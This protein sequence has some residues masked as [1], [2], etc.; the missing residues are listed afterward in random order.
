MSLKSISNS[1]AAQASSVDG[2]V[3]S[4]LQW[5]SCLQEQWLIVFD[6]ADD[7]LPETVAN[8]IPPGN[9]G[10]ILMTSRNQSM[11]TVIAFEKYIEITEM[12]E[13][14]AIDLLLKTSCVDQAEQ[15]ISA[16]QKIVAEL[17]YIPLA[18]NHAGAYIEAGKSD[19]SHYLRRFL[20]H[21]QALMSDPTFTGR[22]NYDRT[23]YG[24]W[25]LSFRE[26]E[27]RA[28][29]QST[30]AQATQA[31]ILIFQICA[32]YHHSNIAK[33]IFRSAAEESRNCIQTVDRKLHQAIHQLLSLDNDGHWDDY[34]FEEGISV[35]FSFSL[36]KRG[37]SSDLFAIHPLVHCWSREQMTKAEKKRMCQLGSTILSCAVSWGETSWDYALRRLILPHIMTN[38]LHMS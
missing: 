31:A 10:N 36:M 1:S 22:S 37:E 38:E 2:S 8:F 18:I 33:D 23:V 28:G 30:A 25:D 21:R 24:T 29:G 20:Q 13:S 12:K 9:Q 5:I 6:N 16:A 32:F 17:G 26:I 27:R 34:V 11:R 35:L 14:D 4:V 7:L 19:I 3:D 15:H